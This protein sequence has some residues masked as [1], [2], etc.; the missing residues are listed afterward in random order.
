MADTRLILGGVVF[1]DFEIPEEISYGVEHRLEHHRLVGAARVTDAMGPEPDPIRW[2]GRFRGRD[3]ISRANR[4][5]RMVALGAVVSLSF[6]G[7]HW[8][9][10]PQHFEADYKR[11]YEIPYSIS[12]EVD[13][14]LGGGL[15]STLT[16]LVSADVSAISGLVGRL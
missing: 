8:R 1:R 4:C 11:F 13:P 15:I 5:E 10:V 6:G 7:K 16:A 9:V 2:R 12:C 3:A 14:G